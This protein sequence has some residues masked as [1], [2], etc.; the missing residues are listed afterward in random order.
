MRIITKLAEC[1][2]ECEDP[3]CPYTHFTSYYVFDELTGITEGPFPTH[4]N[5][6]YFIKKVFDIRRKIC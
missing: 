2:K 3:E 6:E 1:W 5:A 4:E